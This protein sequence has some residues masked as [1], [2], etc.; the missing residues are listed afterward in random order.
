MLASC[1]AL[2]FVNPVLHQLAVVMCCDDRKSR[3]WHESNE[4]SA[5]CEREF[6]SAFASE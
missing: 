5:G 4:S 6:L 3:V 1:P 2:S